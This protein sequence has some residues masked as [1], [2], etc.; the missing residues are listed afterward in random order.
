MVVLTIAQPRGFSCYV[1]E[2]AQPIEM[3]KPLTQPYL[4]DDPYMRITETF[5]TIAFCIRKQA[6]MIAQSGTF[7]LT[8]RKKRVTA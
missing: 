5:K 7:F 8:L 4:V 1:L 2:Q 6:F 3:Q